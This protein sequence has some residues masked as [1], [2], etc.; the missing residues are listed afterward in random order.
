MLIR[1]LGMALTVLLV[2]FDVL[3]AQTSEDREVSLYNIENG[4]LIYTYHSGSNQYVSADYAYSLSG[5]WREYAN[6]DVR[7]FE[8]GSLQ[9]KNSAR[10]NLCLD[11]YGDGY[12][13]T[14]D[15]CHGATPANSNQK[16][17]LV[18]TERGGALLMVRGQCLYTYAGNQYYYVYSDDCPADGTVVDSKWLWALIPPLKD[19]KKAGT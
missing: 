15:T 2:L 14:Q 10:S 6:W 12:Q 8:D 3:S 7:Y 18:P 11:W 17:H 1:A 13:V 9:F 5:S 19:S 16:F 4:T